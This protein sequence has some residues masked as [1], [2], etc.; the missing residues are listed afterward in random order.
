[1]QVTG[2]PEKERP[3]GPLEKGVEAT[4]KKAEIGRKRAA[5]RLD[6]V[7]S[8]IDQAGHQFARKT[9]RWEENVFHIVSNPIRNASDYIEG[10]DVEDQMG[11]A[12]ANI[13]RN[14]SRALLI[15]LG[16]GLLLGFIV[17]RR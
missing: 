9:G 14:P 11:R 5:G 10:L 4:E 13:R 8:K 16:A 15:A 6:Q 7:A 3:E 2:G 12:V 17:G 1:M